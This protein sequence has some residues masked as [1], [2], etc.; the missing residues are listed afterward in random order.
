[1]SENRDHLHAIMP[2]PPSAYKMRAKL[3]D[4]VLQCPSLPLLKT[5]TAFPFKIPFT[6]HDLRPWFTRTMRLKIVPA[7]ESRCV[8]QASSANRD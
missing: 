8:K 6:K 4:E 2:L 1:M 5:P 3:R 7:C